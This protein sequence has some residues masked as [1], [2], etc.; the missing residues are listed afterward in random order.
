LGSRGG[1]RVSRHDQADARRRGARVLAMELLPVV[2]AMHEE[3]AGALALDWN[4]R[5][6]LNV[7]ALHTP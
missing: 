5:S 3:V 6:H 7:I 2:K 4:N 1:T